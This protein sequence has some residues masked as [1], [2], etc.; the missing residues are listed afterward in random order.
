MKLLK[1][2][3]FS[4]IISGTLVAQTPTK[5]ELNTEKSGATPTGIITGTI[6]DGPQGNAVEF[7]TISLYVSGNDRMIDGTITDSKGQFILENLKDGSYWIEISYLGFA[8]ISQTDINI[9]NGETR[10][11]QNIALAEDS[12]LLDEIIVTAQKSLIEE[13]VDRLVYNAENDKLSRGGDAADVLRRVPLLQVDLEG[14]VS[15]RGNSNIRVLI[16]N[17]PST[18][19]ASS[20]ADAMK[21]IPADMIKTVEVITSPSAKYDAEGSGGIINIITKKN[22][23]EGYYLNVNTGL[24]LRGSNLGLNGSYR[25]GKFGLTLGGF[26]RAFYNKAETSM[27]QFTTINGI[28]NQTLQSAN[29]SDNGIFGRYNLGFDY[30]ITDSQFLSGGIR[31]GI[32]SFSRDQLLNTALY[33][34]EE[35]LTQNLRDIN[36]LNF[37]GNTDVNVDYLKVFGSQHEWSISTLYSRDNGNS[38][39]LSEN[40]DEDKILINSIKNL[41]NNLN[42]EITV[43]TDYITPIGTKQILEFGGKGILRKVSS[44]YSYLFAQAGEELSIDYGRP[45]GT[46]DYEQ[47][48]A[49]AY[50]SYTATLPKSY[51]LK[52]GLRWEQTFISAIQDLEEINIPNYSNFVPSVNLSK[53]LTKTTTVKLG[54][55]RRIQRPWLRQLNPNVNIS[56]N[57]DIQVGNPSLKPE[58]TDNVELGLST[59]VKKTYLN[60]STFARNTANAINQVRYPIT[61]TPGAIL[62]TY[63]NIGTERALGIN[64]FVNIY[65]TN[66][67]T[68]NGGIDGYYA[69]LEGQVVG[70]NGESIMAQNQGINFGGRLMS[71]LKLNDGW[72]MQAFTFMRGRRIELQGSRGGFGMYALG[73][74]K[75]LKN[76]SI[77]IAAENFANRGWKIQSELV[78]PTFTQT[79]T[80]LLLNRSVRVNFTYKLGSLDAKSAAKKTR[81]VSNDDLM[82]GGDDNGQSAQGATTPQTKRSNRSAKKDEKKTTKSTKETKKKA[83]E[84]RN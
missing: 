6:N 66:N 11:L 8:K 69:M 3:L 68:I 54:Y 67:W 22:N 25:K 31:Y 33:Q 61:D 1:I 49:A 71:Q 30:D 27:Q 21:M 20:V 7:A 79:N 72:S 76:G 75:E 64:A 15:M 65:L 28:V 23:L 12:E 42:E 39:F 82:S 55:N 84:E 60:I 58:L 52:A 80:M 73:V 40:L 41:D 34:D 74:N 77:G 16:N 19:M 50:S 17:K 38:N 18:I 63:E 81:S 35:L 53:P 14:N 56:N 59:M 45:A 44:D 48:I 37:S 29:A 47:N 70:A 36:S 46:L 4:V 10:D 78:S 62:T 5:T 32:R 51:T 43:Q 2:I 9:V 57:Q 83:K 13:K 26:G 24:G